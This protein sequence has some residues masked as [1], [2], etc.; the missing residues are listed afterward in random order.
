MRVAKTSTAKPL[1]HGV[2]NVRSD[3]M[4]MKTFVLKNYMLLQLQ[5]FF[6][7]CFTKYALIPVL[8]TG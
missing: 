3:F 7:K 6:T 2:V 4:V 1:I 8:R 5:C